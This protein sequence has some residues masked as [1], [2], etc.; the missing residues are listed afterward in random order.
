MRQK[1][2]CPPA[3]GTLV[4]AMCNQAR[5][6][7]TV[8]PRTPTRCTRA[9]AAV[10]VIRFPRR[11]PPSSCCCCCCCYCYCY[12]YYSSSS[13]SS[14]SPSRP[15]DRFR[16]GV[17]RPI[18]K[19]ATAILTVRTSA[20]AFFYLLSQT[21]AKFIACALETR[22]LSLNVKHEI[23]IYGDSY[24]CFVCEVHHRRYR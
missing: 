23:F 16:N 8:L 19:F 3:R 2:L 9:Y 6:M 12:C 7:A 14:T 5:S 18:G 10:S 11:T 4:I 24:W 21:R 17:S 1:A 15:V 20:S 22:T 13:S